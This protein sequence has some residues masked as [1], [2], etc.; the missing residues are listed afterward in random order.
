VSQTA[1]GARAARPRAGVAR[2][3]IEEPRQGAGALKD[4]QGGLEKLVRELR[5]ALERID[6]F[7]TDSKDAFA[8]AAWQT[9]LAS[10]RQA[11][12]PSARSAPAA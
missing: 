1:V 8:E 12:R 9:R 2:C 7:P 11:A 6:K 10:G 5:R 4:Q 3:R